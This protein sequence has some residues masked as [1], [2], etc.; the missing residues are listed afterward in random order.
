MSYFYSTQFAE[1]PMKQQHLLDRIHKL[2]KYEKICRF[3]SRLRK[4]LINTKVDFMRELSSCSSLP[5]DFLMVSMSEI[6]QFVQFDD[7]AVATKYQIHFYIFRNSQLGA[8]LISQFFSNFSTIFL[9]IVS[10]ISSAIFSTFFPQFF[11]QF[12]S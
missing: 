4:H 9:T 7:Q 3:L 1:V 5:H 2:W 11:P 6:R 12:F 10:T 8:H